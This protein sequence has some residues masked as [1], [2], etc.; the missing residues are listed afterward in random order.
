VRITLSFDNGPIPG[1]TDRI[2]DILKARGLR[3]TFF[4]LGKLAA[5]REGYDV[6]IRAK[7][8]GHWIG[9]HTMNHGTPLGESTDPRHVENE[10]EAAERV[11]GPLA[12][13]ERLFR[14]NGGGELGGHL[15]SPQARDW[16]AARKYKVVTWNNVPGDWIEPRRG[17]V[18]RALATA[19][20]QDWSLLVLHDPY[21]A[22]MMDTLP[23]F[24]EEVKR[25]GGSFTQEFPPS[26]ILPTSS[27]GA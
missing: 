24:L 9:N 11:L 25:R 8:E 3:A 12:L 2:L 18:E 26:C 4:A 17:W 20:A 14:P 21:L 7:A 22:D 6:L 16:L 10:I 15:L 23:A 5:E 1:S 19:Q 13:P 27:A